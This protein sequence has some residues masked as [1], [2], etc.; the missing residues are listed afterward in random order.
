MDGDDGLEGVVLR[1]RGGRRTVELNVAACGESCPAVKWHDH[2]RIDAQEFARGGK[3]DQ[4]GFGT[5]AV[6]GTREGVAFAG[7]R[8]LRPVRKQENLSA[9]Y[10]EERFR[11]GE[12]SGKSRGEQDIV[13]EDEGGGHVL[14]DHPTIDG[15]MGERAADLPGCV[16]PAACQQR[17]EAGD[18][19]A[20][21]GW[22]ERGTV[23]GGHAYRL[24]A[25]LGEACLCG[26]KPVRVPVE[27]DEE[28][29]HGK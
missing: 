8:F 2:R 17:V 22:R 1:G 24:H 27:V 14:I 6:P 4:I 7:K 29:C 3:S 15:V 18:G 5:V 26:G 13:L 25:H 19:G 9:I 10:V 21:C 28:G 20:P 11:G 23:H 12:R 16:E